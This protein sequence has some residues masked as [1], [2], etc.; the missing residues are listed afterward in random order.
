MPPYSSF[1]IHHSSFIIHH[2]S[3]II[4]HSSFIVHRSSFVTRSGHFSLPPNRRRRFARNVVPPPVHAFDFVDDSICG[5]GQ[6][7]VRQPRPIGSHKIVGG[8]GAQRDGFFVSAPVA[9]HADQFHRKQHVKR[10]HR[11]AF[12]HSGG[13]Q[14]VGED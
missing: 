2:S 10:L 12:E 14:F 3:F 13:A 9:H 8:Y 1:I 6:Q 5:A 4:H 7:F 11:V